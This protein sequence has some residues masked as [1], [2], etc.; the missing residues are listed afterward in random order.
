[1]DIY[2]TIHEAVRERW[3]NREVFW[4]KDATENY[5][6]GILYVNTKEGFSARLLLDTTKEYVIIK[7]AKISIDM[8]PQDRCDAYRKA[9]LEKYMTNLLI[10][11]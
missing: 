10:Q 4:K 8:W 6:T 7:D 11:F 3:P 2:Q 1:M 5:Y 9:A